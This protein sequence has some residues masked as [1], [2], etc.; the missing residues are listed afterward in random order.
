MSIVIVVK[1]S[2]GVVLGAD[3][4]A[5]LSGQLKDPAGSVYNGVLKTFYNARKLLQVGDFPIG[6]L[7][8]GG[9]FIG[10][11]TLES[12][13]REWEHNEHWLRRESF[14][15]KHSTA[16][17]QA[18]HCADGLHAHLSRVYAE[19]YACISAEQ[20]PQIGIIVAGY[21]DGAFFPEI[22][23]F[24]L[25]H[26]TEVHNQRPDKDGKPDFGASWFGV[27]EPIVRLHFGRDELVGR[28]LSERFKIPEAEIWE[29][30][31]PLQY[32]VAFPQMPLQDAIDYAVYVLN[33]AVGRFR[34]V[35]GPELCGGQ[36]DI[37]VITQNEFTWICQKS[38]RA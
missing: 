31:K 8:W 27:T 19:E 11:R 12:H 9:A 13:V 23:R 4:A 34:F 28:I 6:V 22:W 16:S 17:F 1:V 2:E 32:P 3:S 21:S 7:S 37:A 10:N 29:A 30:L 15:D 25:P 38:W 5:T 20:R 26:D 33:V 18:K 36:L 24:V 35:L 14:P